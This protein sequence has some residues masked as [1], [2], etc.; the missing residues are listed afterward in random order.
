MNKYFIILGVLLGLFA[1]F[2]VWQRLE[3]QNERVRPVAYLAI[4]QD[5]DGRILPEGATIDASD[6]DQISLPANTTAF[7][8]QTRLIRD[9]AANREW[10][11]GARINAPLPP[12]RVLTYDIFEP[13]VGVRLDTLISKGMRATTI[14]V[15]TENSLN[16]K[17]VP[18]NRIDIAGVVE[19]ENG[20]PDTG[21]MILEDV[22]VLAVGD[23][24]SLSEFEQGRSGN[25]STITIE[26]TDTQALELVQKRETLQ[27][28]FNLLLRNQCDTLSPNVT[29]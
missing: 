14:N 17:I 13:L 6:L 18:G 2:L 28:G 22:R 27:G 10:V 8:V 26:V 25:Y 23:A 4:S 7:G 9:T 19:G 20:N 29:C 11:Q 16:N 12:G 3:E 24:T 1:T 21:T 5:L 15:N